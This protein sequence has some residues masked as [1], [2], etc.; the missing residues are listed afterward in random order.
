MANV[1]T[2]VTFEIRV[3]IREVVCKLKHEKE[4]FS[5]FNLH[6]AKIKTFKGPSY[7]LR[8]FSGNLKL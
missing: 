3:S 7:T 8:L 5:C 4:K 2:K 1:R 6:R